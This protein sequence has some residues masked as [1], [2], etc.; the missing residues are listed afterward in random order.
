MSTSIIAS[1]AVIGAGTTY[2]DF[3]R[4]GEAV[5]IGDGCRIGHH[6]VIHDGSLIGGNVRIDD[7]T[8]IGKEPMRAANSA[9][10]KEQQLPSAQ[11]APCGL[12][13]L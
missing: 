2:G 3:C 12:T 1:S 13:T 7:G 11:I 4:I 5:S 6:V 9:V 8:V 10:T